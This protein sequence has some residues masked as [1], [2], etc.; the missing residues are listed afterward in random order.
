M[1]KLFIN[2][3]KRLPIPL[4]V[5][6]KLEQLIKDRKLSPGSKLPVET[7]L[8]NMLGVS[9]GSLREALHI[10]EEEGV[11]VRQHGIGTFVREKLRFVRNPL[12]VNFGVS[13]IIESMGLRAGT[14][15]LKIV[16]DKAN[17]SIS[18]KLKIDTGSSIVILKRVRT[19][20]E[21]PVVYTADILPETI[22]GEV[23]TLKTF[24]GSLYKFLEGKY[25][26]KADYGVAKIIPTLANSDISKRLGIP[27]KSVV[28]LIDQVDYNFR[29]QPIM[30]SQE[31]WRTDIFEFTIFRRRR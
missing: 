18:E 19:A 2:K 11:I 10:L 22:L 21:K 23:G 12:E 24:S 28:L 4:V 26:Q 7:D 1:E 31:Y 17:S 25:G 29:N 3:L 5:K 9:R 14:A 6:D 13:E 15:E 20:D 30:Y 16:R 27:A 8:A